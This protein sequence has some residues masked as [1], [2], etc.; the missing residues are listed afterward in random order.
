METKDIHFFLSKILKIKNPEDYDLTVEEINSI[1]FP[2]NKY[3]IIGVYGKGS[4]G[5]IFKVRSN[6]IY[7]NIFACKV[8]QFRHSDQNT[9]S[10]FMIQQQFAK[11]HMA[12]R[13]YSYDIVTTELEVDVEEDVQN[14]NKTQSQQL[15]F[16]TFKFGRAL[17]NYISAT[18][19]EFITEH[20][21]DV[22]QIVPALKDLI[23]KKF[24]LKYPLPFLHS[25]MHLDN[26]VLLKDKRTLGF[27]D[28]GLS[29]QR[30][31]GLQ[32]LDC[33]PLITSLK[34]YF[35]KRGL[36]MNICIA[37]LDLYNKLFNVNLNLHLF[38]KHPGGG[39]AYN[40][41]GILLHSYNWKPT[42]V[43]NPT[44]VDIRQLKTCFPTFQA[45][46][47]R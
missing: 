10:E 40:A 17:M 38:Q 45:P 28:F 31:Y 22:K 2:L 11:Y 32:L 20:Y 26:I 16:R 12:P 27:I 41:N 3:K 24:I 6:D 37:I 46:Q 47:S 1:V 34:F 43:R 23:E 13:I 8:I 30:H 9:L 36:P 18:L 21:P 25:D 33:I 5:L 29:V 39:Y 7:E 42:E 4:H 19:K 44:I 15:V 35:Q 14:A